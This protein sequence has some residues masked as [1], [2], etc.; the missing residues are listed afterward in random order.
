[1]PPALRKRLAFPVCAAATPAHLPT[2]PSMFILT[3]LV[4][5]VSR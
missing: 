1:M 2:G 3:G 5:V 4:Q